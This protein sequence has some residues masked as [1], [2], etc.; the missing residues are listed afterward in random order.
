MNKQ[1]VSFVTAGDPSMEKTKE[2]IDVLAEYSD[3]IE[4]GIP[5]SDPVAEGPVIEMANVRALSAGVT[6]DDV[7]SMLEEVSFPKMVIL[8][9]FNPVF[10]YGLDRFFAECKRTKVYAVII[11]DVPY[12]ERDEV[13]VHSKR[14]G[15]HFITMIAPTSAERVK[16]LAKDAA[17][18]IYLVSSMGVTGIRSELSVDLTKIVEQIREVTDT[19]IMIGFGISDRKQADM[20]RGIADGVIVG[21]A[22]V[23]IIAEHGN[24]SAPKIRQFLKEIN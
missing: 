1:F 14:Y 8:T 6:T 10:V 17:G 2:F 4:I 20:M 24:D 19:P 7:F 5:F 12:E 22:I 21:S 18:F 13:L 23:G 16:M 15:V 9:Y 11:P 3:I